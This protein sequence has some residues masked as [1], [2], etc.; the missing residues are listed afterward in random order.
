MPSC[1]SLLL[2]SIYYHNKKQKEAAEKVSSLRSLTMF[3]RL[4]AAGHAG[5]H[6]PYVCWVQAVA[7]VNEQLSKSI[8]RRVLGTKVV[9]TIEPAQDYYLAEDYHQQ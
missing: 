6:M 4:P 1:V 8:F 7:S 2:Q 3:A 9:T 5:L